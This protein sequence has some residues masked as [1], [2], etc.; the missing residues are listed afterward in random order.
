MLFCSLIVAMVTV[1]VKNGVSKSKEAGLRFF[2]YPFFWHQLWVTFMQ[3]WGISILTKTNF[4]EMNSFHGNSET[5]E[6][7]GFKKNMN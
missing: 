5:Y 6:R 1:K 4:R 2:Y 7:S 3:I